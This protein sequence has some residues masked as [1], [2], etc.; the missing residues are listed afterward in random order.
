MDYLSA[1]VLVILF[2]AA[3]NAKLASSSSSSSSVS[4]IFIFGDSTA[5]PGN[6]NYISTYF[7]SNFPPYGKDFLNHTPTGRFTNGRLANDFISQYIGIKDY[8]P[9]Y[10]DPTLSIQELMTGVSFASAGSGFDPLTPAISSV[11]S[12]WEQLEQFREYK[13]K[14]EA[15]VGK[16]KTKELINNAIYFVS[17]GTNDFVVNYFTMPIRRRTYT[18]PT[19]TTFLLQHAR[20]FF[21]GLL[22]EGGRRIGVAGLPP[23]GCLPVVITLYTDNHGKRDCIDY[24]SSVARN[25]NEMLEKQLKDMQIKQPQQSRSR[26]AYIDIYGPLH[27]MILLGSKYDFEEVS[28]GCCGTGLL[29]ASYLCNRESRLCSDANKFVFWDSIHPTQRSYFVMFQ[30]LRPVIDALLI[31]H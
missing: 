14:V 26:I 27:D 23:M 8:V 6:N 28:S 29:E 4:A 10:L 22:D 17:A 2:T 20:Q 12:M 21:Q 9:P 18:I 15:A 7:Q 30:S 19:Y 5:D 13:A 31:H 1:L 11:I 3:A 25:Y 24:F 16:D